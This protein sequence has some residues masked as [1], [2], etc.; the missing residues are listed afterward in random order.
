MTRVE[1][2]FPPPL[3]ACFNHPPRWSKKLNRWTAPKITSKRYKEWQTAAHNMLRKQAF[4]TMLD[5]Q[6]SV[7][8]RLVAPDR[9]ERDDGNTDKAVKDMLVKAGIITNDSNRYV[10]MTTIAWAK[11]GPPCVVYIRPF[12]EAE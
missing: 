3:S 4:E 11:S 9:R 5:Q 2:P 12:E 8:I 7:L 6:V 1:L 10:M